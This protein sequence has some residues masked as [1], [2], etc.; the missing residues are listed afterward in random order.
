MG[1]LGPQQDIGD[2]L[3]LEKDPRSNFKAEYGKFAT[4]VR[5]LRSPTPNYSLLC[6][7]S[8]SDVLAWLYERRRRAYL[9][10]ATA[11]ADNRS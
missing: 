8:C 4:S 10:L 2:Q 6:V 1:F 5:G 3:S 11:V 9:R 7:R